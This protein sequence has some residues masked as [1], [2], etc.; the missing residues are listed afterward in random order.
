MIVKRLNNEIFIKI[1]GKIPPSRIQLIVDYLRY[2][3][4][5]ANS[6]ATQE[7]VDIL[8]SE[9]KKGRWDRIKRETGL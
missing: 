1:S 8:T 7:D 4:L 5:T 2:E 9:V 3:E 6:R